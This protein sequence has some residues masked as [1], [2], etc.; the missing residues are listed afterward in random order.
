MTH[1]ERKRVD[2]VREVTN[3]NGTFYEVRYCCEHYDDEITPAP[4]IEAVTEEQPVIIPAKPATYTKNAKDKL[5]LASKAVKK[6]TQMTKGEPALY[7]EKGKVIKESIEPEPVMQTVVI[8]PAVE[9]VTDVV[10]F[11]NYHRC[12]IDASGDIPADVQE[13]IDNAKL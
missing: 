8:T 3:E 2:Q 9:A 6:H 13:F 1:L 5:V 11:N 12:V 4:A 7:D 10:K